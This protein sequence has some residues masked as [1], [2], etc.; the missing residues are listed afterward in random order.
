MLEVINGRSIYA[1]QIYR[2]FKNKLYQIVTVA[3]HSETGEKLVIYQQ[4]Y[5]G[6]EVYAR[7]LEMFMSEVD[8]DKYPMAEQKYRFELVEREELVNAGNGMNVQKDKFAEELSIT[9]QNDYFFEEKVA[10]RM[11]NVEDAQDGN[12]SDVMN[13]KSDYKKEISNSNMQ[14]NETIN[15]YLLKFLDADTYE[16][17]RNILIRMKGEMTNRLIDDIAASLD[18]AVENGNIEERY[19]SLLNCID[20]MVKY[21]VNRFR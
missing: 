12:T 5:G 4:L 10:D 17:K 18:V 9:N 19:I 8:R 14:E 15:P 11:K 1:G 6:Y 21:E 13:D 2:H 3:N 7:P 16:E 20:M